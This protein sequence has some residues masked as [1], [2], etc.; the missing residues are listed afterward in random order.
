MISC[1][2]NHVWK[3]WDDVRSYSIFGDARNILGSSGMSKNLAY[4]TFGLI[5]YAFSEFPGVTRRPR[6]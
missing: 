1:A 3:R 2:P 4:D 5:H 6:R